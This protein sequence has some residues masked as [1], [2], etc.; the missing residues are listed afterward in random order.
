MTARCPAGP[1]RGRG[2]GRLGR[3]GRRLRHPGHR[4]DR[5]V[6]VQL[7]AD[8]PGH[9]LGLGVLIALL[10]P[11]SGA[12]LQPLVT[13]AAW[14]T[15]RRG[16]DGPDRAGRRLCP[17]PDRG[18]RRRT[19]VPMRCSASRWCSGP[20]TTR[21]AGHLWLARSSRPP[22][23]PAV[24][25]WPARAADPPGPVAVASYIGAAY[26]FTSTSFANPSVTIGR[27]FTDTVRRHRPRLARPV[28]RGPTGRR[29]AGTGPGARR[30]RTPGTAQTA[31]V[32]APGRTRTPATTLP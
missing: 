28:H 19:I 18:S 10:G 11:V 14:A 25:A 1:R 21:F 32:T 24:L 2:F 20:R 3:S 6:G 4:A 23:H 5:D 17:G 26:W 13:L 9:R 22:G 8:F 29:R 12:P 30:V 16:K 15:G 31:A 7:L 27:T